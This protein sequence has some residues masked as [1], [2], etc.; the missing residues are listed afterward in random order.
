M[1][2]PATWFQMSLSPENVSAGHVD[3]IQDTFAE[4]LI[5]ASAPPGA[6]MFGA[7]RDDGGADLFFTPSAAKIA[8][9]LLKQNGAVACL[10]PVTDGNIALLVGEKADQRLLSS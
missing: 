6:A 8:A 7:S 3:R 10:P 4:L 9:D 1:V 2:Q 5:D